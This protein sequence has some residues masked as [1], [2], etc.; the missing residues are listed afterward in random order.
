M[1]ETHDIMHFK[2]PVSIDKND[3]TT[4]KRPVMVRNV[5]TAS[6]LMGR[7][8]LEIQKD[9]IGGEKAKLLIYGLSHFVNIHRDHVLEGR[10]E[11]LE[12]SLKRC[13]K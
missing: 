10:V 5:K 3:A 13:E 1:S 4:Q 11:A 12:N 8:L 2:P 9:Q 7:I 6:R